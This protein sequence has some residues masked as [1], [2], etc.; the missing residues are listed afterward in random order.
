MGH[1]HDDEVVETALTRLESND[2]DKV[3]P[4]MKWIATKTRLHGLLTSVSEELPDVPL[5]YTLPDLCS[6][7]HC[8]CPPMIKMKAA[9]VNAG[10]RVSAYHKE[11]QAIKTDAPNQVIW[12]IL[13]AWCKENP[14]QTSA[15]RSKQEQDNDAKN[16]ILAAESS[17]EVDFEV[18]KGL[19]QRKKA[20]RYPANP[21][22][23]WGPKPRASGRKRKAV[24]TSNGDE[25]GGE[26][27]SVVG[28]E[29]SR[30][31]KSSES[32]RA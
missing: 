18:P 4:D 13:R 25:R 17:I 8:T 19:D 10:Y 2:S 16:K 20:Q 30:N 24:E 23:N 22:K 3:V 31:D 26:Q 27:T 15:K 32:T 29:K 11:P 5:Y 7:L 1:L 12:D 6:T 9:L 21:E 14:P 28:D